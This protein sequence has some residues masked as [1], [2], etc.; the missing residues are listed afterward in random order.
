MTKKKS[1][2]LITPEAIRAIQNM[3]GPYDYSKTQA[4]L[5]EAHKRTQEA[6]R[7]LKHPAGVPFVEVYE[8][9]MQDPEMQ[10][11]NQAVAEKVQEFIDSCGQLPSARE[12]ID[13]VLG[14]Y[15]LQLP[16]DFPVSHDTLDRLFPEFKDLW[17]KWR[18]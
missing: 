9:I 8:R 12:L 6:L 17:E 7:E 15:D 2:G 5:D 3:H 14:Q 4:S 1:D 13:F 11:I 16:E 10:E 18:A